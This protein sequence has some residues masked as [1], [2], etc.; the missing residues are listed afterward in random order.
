MT[1]RERD[2]LEQSIDA[3]K[4]KQLALARPS[5]TLQVQM[6][7]LDWMWL[8]VG[9]DF[10]YDNQWLLRA[11]DVCVAEEQ[12]LSAMASLLNTWGETVKIAIIVD[13]KG[14]GVNGGDFLTG[15]WRKRDLNYKLDPENL[16][17]VNS[18]NVVINAAGNY[19]IVASA[20]ASEVYYHNVRLLRNG[21]E[22][23]LG[24]NAD[25][26]ASHVVTRSRVVF[27]GSLA[28]NDV[29]TLEHRCYQS[30]TVYGFGYANNFTTNNIYSVMEVFKL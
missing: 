15:A 5:Q 25:C 23:A 18:N 3:D 24:E 13:Q 20:P 1:F 11:T 8:G 9:I 22:V 10:L 30:K 26:I 12:I 4:V 7:A 14:N 2:P 21:V 16:V 28:A 29:L 6:S 27:V 19:Y 17:T